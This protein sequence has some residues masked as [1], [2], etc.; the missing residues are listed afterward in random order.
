[1]ELALFFASSLK[2]ALLFQCPNAW[3]TRPNEAER[4][5]HRC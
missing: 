4:N 1:M 2:L 5:E 3:L